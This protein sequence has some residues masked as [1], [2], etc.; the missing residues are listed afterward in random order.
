MNWKMW[1]AGVAVLAAAGVG[2]A[3]T[4][5]AA[6]PE[7]PTCTADEVPVWA[8]H[9]KVDLFRRRACEA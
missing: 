9:G 4:T 6:D 5:E 2:L 1:A 3:V 7:V 8:P